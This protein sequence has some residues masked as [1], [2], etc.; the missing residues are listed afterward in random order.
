VYWAVG[1]TAAMMGSIWRSALDGSGA[2]A[3]VQGQNYPGCVAVDQTSVYWINE[4]GGMVSKT[5]K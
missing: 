1:G 4:N 2:V 5:G 3:L